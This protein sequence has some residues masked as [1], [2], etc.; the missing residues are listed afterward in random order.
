MSLEYAP[1]PITF[2]QAK[3][4]A[5][6]F[7][8]MSTDRAGDPSPPSWWDHELGGWDRE[9]SQADH[10]RPLKRADLDPTSPSYNFQSFSMPMDAIESVYDMQAFFYTVDTP[11][12]KPWGCLSRAH[13]GYA[14]GA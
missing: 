7:V 6:A 2:L 3:P 10:L 4:L 5:V 1:S 13:L 12:P 8:R 9:Y 14:S 11:T